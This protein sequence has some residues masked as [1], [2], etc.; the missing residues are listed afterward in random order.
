[1]MEVKGIAVK[2]IPEFVQHQF[3][4]KIT[5]WFKNL[6]SDSQ[7][8]FNQGIITSNWY[9]V[10]PAIVQPTQTINLLFYNN[11][12]KGAWELGRYSAEV[13]LK[14]IYKIYIK[15]SSPAHI[16]E[17][18]G[19]VFSAYYQPSEMIVKNFKTNYVLVAITKFPEPHEIIENRIGGWMQKALEISG[20]KNVDVKIVQSLTQGAKET[21]YELKWV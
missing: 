17:R 11:S 10:K 14:G 5:E 20:C 3:P 6:P 13:A 2:S 15:L 19:R 7:K 21:L 1:M 12:M 18:A 16:V 8:I 4:D 9:P